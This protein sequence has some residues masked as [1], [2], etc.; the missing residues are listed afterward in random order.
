[1]KCIMPSIKTYKCNETNE[2]HIVTPPFS[3]AYTRVT[4]QL[5]HVKWVDFYFANIPNTKFLAHYTVTVVSCD[6]VRDTFCYVLVELTAVPQQ[7]PQHHQVQPKCVILLPSGGKM[8]A[9]YCQL[10]T[11]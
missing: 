6:I 10:N 4:F 1:M 8:Q 11:L 7:G 5:K 3:L 9:F 2:N